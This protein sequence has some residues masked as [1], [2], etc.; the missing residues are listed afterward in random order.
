MTE[1]EHLRKEGAAALQRKEWDV[2]SLFAKQSREK[3]VEK[4]PAKLVEEVK[5]ARDLLLE[6]KVRGGDLKRPIQILKKA[7]MTLKEE[8]YVDAL[9]LLKVFR[10]EI[11]DM[12]SG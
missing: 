3:L 10:K 4:L 1:A 6:L 2:A 7:S 12:Q 8:R 11:R 9:R 5:R